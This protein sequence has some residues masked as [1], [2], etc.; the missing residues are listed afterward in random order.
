MP[1]V[2]SVIEFLFAEI[3]TKANIRPTSYSAIVFHGLIIAS[4][5]K[6]YALFL[7][8]PIFVAVLTTAGH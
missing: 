6:K 8:P 5:V 3:N 2:C 4:L 7:K 1:A